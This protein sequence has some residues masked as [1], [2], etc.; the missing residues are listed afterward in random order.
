M[1][2]VNGCSRLMSEGTGSGQTQRHRAVQKM[3]QDVSLAAPVPRARV[4][5]VMVAL[6]LLT[7]IGLAPQ[8]HAQGRPGD[9]LV[10]DLSAGTGSLGRYS[11]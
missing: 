6:V 9:A 4:S 5:A 10:I 7:T 2:W 8:A 1:Q 11:E 3:A